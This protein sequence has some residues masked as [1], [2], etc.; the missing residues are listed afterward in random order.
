ML[1]FQ[2]ERL[3]I[4]KCLSSRLSVSEDVDLEVIAS[5]TEYFSGADLQALLYTANI[6]ALHD[7]QSTS[8]R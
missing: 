3:D 2:A 6:E 7:S 8:T 5:K 1:C 4:L